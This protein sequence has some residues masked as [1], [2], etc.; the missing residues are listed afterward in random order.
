MTEFRD[1]SFDPKSGNSGTRRHP[2]V[3]TKPELDL[4]FTTNHQTSVPT[5]QSFSPK[6]R[7]ET[8]NDRD[9]L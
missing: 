3:Y 5:P 7:V 8:V 6:I 2:I 9:L 1:S 4:P